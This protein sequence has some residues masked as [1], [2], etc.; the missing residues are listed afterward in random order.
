M[1][2]LKNFRCLC[3]QGEAQ[4]KIVKEIEACLVT[5]DSLRNRLLAELGNV[6]LR[7]T[8][9]GKVFSDVGNSSLNLSG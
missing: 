5:L 2:L 8:L 9:A 7:L 6:R 4:T 3:R 1:R